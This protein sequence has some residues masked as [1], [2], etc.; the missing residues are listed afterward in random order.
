MTTH[1]RIKARTKEIVVGGAYFLS[2]FFEKDGAMVKIISTSTEIN[3]A[4]W[5]STVEYE[6]LKRIGKTRHVITHYPKGRTGTCNATNLY[7]NR[8]DASH[9]NR[10]KIN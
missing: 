2:S 6:V 9:S 1:E 7:E 3:S 8:E 4:G 10:L 5:P